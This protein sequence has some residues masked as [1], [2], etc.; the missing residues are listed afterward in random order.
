[1]DPQEL[2]LKLEELKNN[3]DQIHNEEFNYNYKLI[4]Y[5]IISVTVIIVAVSTII[6]F[7][8]PQIISFQ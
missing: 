3:Q 5:T 8:N 4:G 1:V 7:N 2:N 6:I